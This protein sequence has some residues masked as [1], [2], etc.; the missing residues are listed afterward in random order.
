MI[1]VN[2]DDGIGLQGHIP[3]SNPLCNALAA[4]RPAVAI[5]QGPQ[6]YVS[7]SWYPSKP[8][9]GKVVPTWNYVVVHAHG[10][11][12]VIED[13]GWLL[14]HLNQLTRQQESGQR[15]PWQ[16]ADAPQEF[17]QRLLSN[18]VGIEIDITSLLGKWKVSQ[19]KNQADQLGV[20]AGLR[21]RGMGDDLAMAALIQSAH[22]EN[23]SPGG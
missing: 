20:I 23:L 7:P 9:H 19:N 11:A 8:K 12:R 10:V 16:L 2:K 14:A 22:D 15:L 18:I 3:R 4:G 21:S 6:A 13:E 17:T 5:F 1:R